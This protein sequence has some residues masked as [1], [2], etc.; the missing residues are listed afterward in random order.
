[1]KIAKYVL[2]IIENVVD[3]GKKS[4]KVNLEIKFK[5]L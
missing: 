3:S 1:M 5:I 4:N 2:K